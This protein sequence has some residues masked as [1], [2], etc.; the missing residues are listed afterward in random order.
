M[1]APAVLAPSLV[2]LILA[3][4]ALAGPATE[5]GAARLL[6][7][8]QTY[9]GKA[10][11]MVSVT[12][13]GDA[14]RLSIDPAPVASAA[15]DG[16]TVKIAPV[17]MMLSDKGDGIW[18]VRQD[19]PWSMDFIMPGKV[20]A[21]ATAARIVFT[22]LFDTGLMAFASSHAS[23]EGLAMVQTQTQPDGGTVRVERLQPGE[24]LDLTS[25][26][27]AGGGV[28]ATM[29]L[30]AGDM[31]EAFDIA[32][33]EGT[34]THVGVTVEGLVADTT[35][36]GLR[37]A[38]IFRLAGFFVGHPSY[39][40]IAFGQGALKQALGEALPLF[41]RMDG[42]V[43]IARLEAKTPV[44][45]IA[46]GPV[47]AAAAIGGVVAEGLLHEHVSAE[48]ISLPPGA[49]P[50]WAAELVPQQ[51]VF[52]VTLKDFDL[53]DPA[54]MVLAALDLSAKPPLPEAIKPDVL[55][56][57]LP[58]GTVTVGTEGMRVANGLYTVT[59]DGALKIGPAGPE[60]G[61]I[62]VTAKGIEAVS[63]VLAKAPPE[64]KQK[65]LFALLGAKGIGKQAPDGTVSWEIG[66]APGG[67]MAVNGMPMPGSK[68]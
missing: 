8:F 13:Q 56:A 27:A 5:E 7:V 46:A 55:K 36:K 24:T 19:Q 65:A 64:I 9:L 17:E 38:G 62:T 18:S 35:V 22:G 21:H 23:I 57:L 39:V 42:T 4:P 59:A 47:R 3:S 50:D 29:H 51:A 61:A 31:T 15:P 33:K 43:S 60:A 54:R 32:P 58:E 10:P 34:P 26:A 45:P 6:A 67:G 2:A 14:Y 25:T 28:D 12:P 11:G 40:S 30:N 53:A 68:K 1:R 52:D 44:G 66:P 48:G 49:V 37:T 16:V 20:E 63:Q 41:D